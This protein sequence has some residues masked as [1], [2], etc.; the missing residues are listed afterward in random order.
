MGY[1]AGIREER[2]WR[3]GMLKREM[4]VGARHE[5]AAAIR[6]GADDDESP[7]RAPYSAKSGAAKAAQAGWQ[8]GKL[9]SQTMGQEDFLF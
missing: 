2:E 1:N 5:G 3:P 8:R 6:P 4:P 9:P 7:G